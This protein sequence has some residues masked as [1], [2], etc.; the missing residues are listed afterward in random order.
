LHCKIH[1]TLS[2]GHLFILLALFFASQN[3]LVFWPA[4]RTPAM[5]KGP[6]A[7]AVAG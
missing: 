5:K 4:Q 7:A 3:A 1:A 2:I 6:S